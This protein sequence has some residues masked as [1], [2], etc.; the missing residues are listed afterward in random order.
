MVTNPTQIAERGNVKILAL[1]P[2][3]AANSVEEAT[4]GPDTDF[5]VS[6]VPWE[7]LIG[8]PWRDN[9]GYAV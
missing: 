5:A 2:E 1:V 6:Q 9:A 7:S 4:I 8:R 3:E